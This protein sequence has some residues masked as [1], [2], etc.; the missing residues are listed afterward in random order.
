[1]VFATYSGMDMH[2]ASERALWAEARAIGAVNKMA[3]TAVHAIAKA[4]AQQIASRK[5]AHRRAMDIAMME[6]EALCVV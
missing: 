2:L 1:M 5:A 4:G 3:R 6:L